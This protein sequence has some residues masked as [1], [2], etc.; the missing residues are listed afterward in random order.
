MGSLY[1][2]LAVLAAYNINLSKIQSMPI[3]GKPWEYLFFVD[4]HIAGTVSYEQAMD[5]IRPL[6]HY[7]R[8]L[9]AYPKGEHYEY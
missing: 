5:A 8:V 9:G 6:T 1:K 3:I 4:F 7:L 2:V